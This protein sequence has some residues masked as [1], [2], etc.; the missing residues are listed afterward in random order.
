MGDQLFESREFNK[1]LYYFSN[2]LKEISLSNNG[3]ADAESNAMHFL[4]YYGIGAETT[5]TNIQDGFPFKKAQSILEHLALS[6]T[7]DIKEAIYF[8]ENVLTHDGFS[9]QP[10]D[11][12]YI[13]GPGSHIKN[14]DKS[15]NDALRLPVTNLSD[16]CTEH[17][18]NI[19]RSKSGFLNWNKG[20]TLFKKQK[21]TASQLSS[22]KKRIHDHKK[23]IES[24]KSPE[25]AKYRLARLEIEK[26]SKLKSLEAAN[27]KLISA[28]KEFKGLK[29]EYTDSQEV[30]RTDL[31]SII[32]QLDD[33]VSYTHLTLPT[34]A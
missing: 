3:E 25:S 2:T 24:A 20:E 22:I 18:K 17:I 15:L 29:D 26:D 33:P 11:Q 12:V 31:D 32:V 30:L 16:Y 9:I 14:L 4:S 6:F 28:S 23:A 13:S 5:D 27:I 34:K 8:F 7:E 1:G 19:E 21:N 10:I